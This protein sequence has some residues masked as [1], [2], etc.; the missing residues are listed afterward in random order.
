[1]EAQPFALGPYTSVVSTLRKYHNHKV[2]LDFLAEVLG[3]TRTEIEEYVNALEREGVV[4][5]Y[6]E[7]VTLADRVSAARV[8]SSR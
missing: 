3:K 8:R 5:R 6:G 1:V 2:E 7:E 4:L